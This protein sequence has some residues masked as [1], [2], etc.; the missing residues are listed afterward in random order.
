MSR[1]GERVRSPKKR[2]YIIRTMDKKK[3]ISRT[4]ERV[5]SP[6]KR[7]YIIRTMDKKNELVVW[8]NVY[9]ALKKENK[10]LELWIKSG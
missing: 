6:K 5:R 2:E 9:G 7:E 8:A 10:Y 1:T 3:R 4:G